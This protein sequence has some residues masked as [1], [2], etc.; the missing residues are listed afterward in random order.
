MEHFV[1][2]RPFGEIYRPVVFVEFLFSDETYGF[3]MLVDTGA[4]NIVLPYAAMSLCGIE[5]ADCAA[6]PGRSLL[7]LGSGL[8]GPEML[9]RLP[10]F[11]D[12]EAFAARIFFA[13]FLDGFSYGLLGRD[14][15]LDYMGFRFGH[16]DAFGFYVSL[17]PG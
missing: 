17:G 10:D 1:P 3:P 12:S 9:V 4:D 11:D 6:V 16:A 15:T 14:P 8:Q 2:Y 13:P 5:V 7:G